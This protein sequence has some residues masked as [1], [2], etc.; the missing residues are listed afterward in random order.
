[1]F[2]LRKELEQCVDNDEL[3]NRVNALKQYNNDSELNIILASRV[4]LDHFSI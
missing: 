4:W 3:I 2:H 1:M